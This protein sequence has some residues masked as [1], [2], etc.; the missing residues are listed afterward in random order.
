MTDTDIRI[1]R[2]IMISYRAW[3]KARQRA[4]ELQTSISRYIESLIETEVDNALERDNGAVRGGEEMGD[5]A[6]SS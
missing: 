3:Q 6:P 1:T 5:H 2:S 4:N